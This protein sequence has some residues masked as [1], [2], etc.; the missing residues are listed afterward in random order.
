MS[1]LDSDRPIVSTA[2]V[3]ECPKLVSG[4]YV[5]TCFCVL[6]IVLSRTACLVKCETQHSCMIHS[7]ELVVCLK[8]FTFISGPD[9]FI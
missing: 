1:V 8:G 6:Q 4:C 2:M 9:W 3:L 7:V 5:Q